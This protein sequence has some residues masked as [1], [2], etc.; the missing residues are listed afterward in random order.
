MYRW[1]MS[2]EAYP[3]TDP[4]SLLN[5]HPLPSTRTL[6]PRLALT[7]TYSNTTQY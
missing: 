6:Y 7:L 4:R 1:Q 5:P 2:L 3:E